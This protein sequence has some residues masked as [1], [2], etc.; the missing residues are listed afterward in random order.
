MEKEL[1]EHTYR[2]E[3][4]HGD[5]EHQFAQDAKKS[6]LKATIMKTAGIHR[7]TGFN[8]GHQRHAVVH[9][10]HK[11]KN[12]VG[13][14]FAD[15]DP[16]SRKAYSSDKEHINDVVDT[17]DYMHS[18][19]HRKAMK[20]DIEVNENHPGQVEAPTT[21]TID[22]PVGLPPL[23]DYKEAISAM[24]SGD[25]N[26]FTDIVND[27]MKQKAQIAVNDVE[28]KTRNDLFNSP[29]ESESESEVE[30]NTEEENEDA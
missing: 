23:A 3:L 8:A 26:K 21:P 25:L 2:F 29:E 7:G 27:A 12:K 19:T 4:D 6:G 22:A 9:L 1:K 10:S 24:V 16:G 5:S 30:T 28:M 13:K 20:E 17:L 11:D 18:V 14:F 15:R